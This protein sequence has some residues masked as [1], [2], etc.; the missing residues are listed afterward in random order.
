MHIAPKA[1]NKANNKTVCPIVIF[2]GLMENCRTDKIEAFM[3]PRPYSHAV[4]KKFIREKKN[5][6]A[7]AIRA[8]AVS[9]A[10]AVCF[11][12]LGVVYNTVPALFSKGYALDEI[13]KVKS[14]ANR[15]PH[16]KLK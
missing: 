15:L 4:S 8:D 7:R 11:R 16:I 2:S 9:F 5:E 3:P 10:A 6:T 1:L 13:S 14:M 12:P